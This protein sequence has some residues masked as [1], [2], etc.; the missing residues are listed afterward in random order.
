MTFLLGAWLKAMNRKAAIAAGNRRRANRT[1]PTRFVPRIEYLEDRTVPSTFQVTNLL[2]HGAG[3]LRQ[4]VLNANA[5]AGA[6]VIKFASGLHGTITL[7]TGE[8]A[9]TDSLTIDGPGANKITVSGNNA[10]RVFDISGSTT[11][12]A[13]DGLTIAHG[14]VNNTTTTGPLGAVAQGGGLL[15]T[16]GHVT[17][18]DV[19]FEDNQA[20]GPQVY[21]QTNLVSDI[22]NLAQLTDPI[23]RTR[24]ALR[25]A[26]P[27]SSRFQTSR[28]TP[29]RCTR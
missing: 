11:D 24:G 4:A 15:N 28:P 2:D 7:T 14:L 17:L 16:G 29:A 10:S 23:S 1:P 18:S 13:I 25:S 19:R 3:S 8:L 5:H 6:D 27:G 21:A 22:P 26:T 12:V 9:I 20:I